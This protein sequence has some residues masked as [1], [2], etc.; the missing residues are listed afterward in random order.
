MQPTTTLLFLSLLSLTVSQ[1]P[2]AADGPIVPFTSVLPPCASNCGP[3]YDVQGKCAPPNIPAVNPNCFCTDT[4]LTPFDNSGT[5]GV[6]QVCVGAGSCTTASD[7][8][9]IKTWY[10]SYCT[11]NKG[12]SGTTTGGSSSPTSTGGGQ[13]KSA[14]QIWLSSH[15][16]WVIMLVVIVVAIVGGWIGACMFRR[17]YIRRKEKEIEMRPPVAWGPHQLQHAT[18]GYNYGEA[19]GDPSKGKGAVGGY[20]KEAAAVVIPANGKRES[21]GW[22]SKKNKY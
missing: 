16:K 3:L 7:L 17:R 10:D 14:G 6:S 13:S 12:T 4:R 15:Y 1:N 20:N 18:G 2:Q 21:K 8:Q 5:S 22:L 11:G 19:I 9:A